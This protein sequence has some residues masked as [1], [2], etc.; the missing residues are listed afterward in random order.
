[1]SD[2]RKCPTLPGA[3]PVSWRGTMP[4]LVSPSVRYEA[5]YRDAMEE[6]VAEGR[7][8]ELRALPQHATFEAFVS[9]LDDYAHGRRLPDGWVPMSTFW[10]V[11]DDCFLGKLEI[12]HQLTELLRRVGG[13]IG[14]CIRP[15]ERCRRYGTQLLALALPKCREIGLNRVLITCD[16]TNLAS[17]RIIEANGGQLE[18][19]VPTEDGVGKI[20][21]WIDLSG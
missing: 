17:R 9:Q 18:D 13:H 7:P 15:S 12:R 11:D 14:Y 6:F 10:L 8:E 21:F 4:A 5:S 2:A 1:M 19:V 3:V 16:T 20:R